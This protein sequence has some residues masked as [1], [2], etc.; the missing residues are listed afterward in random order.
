MARAQIEGEHAYNSNVLVPSHNWHAHQASSV[1]VH[2]V[3]PARRAARGNAAPLFSSSLLSGRR[4]VQLIRLRYIAIDGLSSPSLSGGPPWSCHQQPE[5]FSPTSST[6]PASIISRWYGPHVACVSLHTCQLQFC[7][8]N[9]LWMLCGLIY[10]GLN[11]SIVVI[12]FV[13]VRPQQPLEKG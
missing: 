11:P 6:C 2:A 5:F 1:A 3:G 7:Y 8:A 4:Q 10:A 13:L 9:A 12:A